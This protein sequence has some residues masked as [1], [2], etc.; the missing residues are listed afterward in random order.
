MKNLDGVLPFKKRI[1]PKLFHLLPRMARINTNIQ[2]KDL[3]GFF[4]FYEKNI[5]GLTRFIA[6]IFTNSR[7]YVIEDCF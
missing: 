3:V 6:I 5:S 7:K 1:Y 2:V 4:I